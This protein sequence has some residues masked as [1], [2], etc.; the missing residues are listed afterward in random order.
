MILTEGEGKD[1]KLLGVLSN[2]LLQLHPVHKTS[3]VKRV[4][5]DKFRINQNIRVA[6]LRVVSALLFSFLSPLQR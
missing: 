6:V 5:H 4:F 3:Q 1:K 2:V